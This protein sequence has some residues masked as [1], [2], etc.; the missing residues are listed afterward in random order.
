[1][2]RPY[3]DPDLP[4]IMEMANRAWRGI[5]EMFRR[6]YGEELFGIVRPNPDTTKGEQVKAFCEETPECCLI[7]EEGGRIV[8]FVTF[9]LDRNTR[10]GEIGNNAVDPDCGL[11]GKGQ[12][13]YRAVLERFRREGMLYAKVATGL[14]EAHAPARRAYERI[15]FNIRH[16]NVT[17]YM[18][19]EP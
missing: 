14:D 10:I 7:C 1:M 5:T 11:K 15:G 16:E 12:E 3:A 8:G 2:I 13:M 18:K 19:L 9:K 17:Y 6:A 4:I